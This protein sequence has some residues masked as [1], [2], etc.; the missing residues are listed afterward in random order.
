MK[1]G[2]SPGLCTLVTQQL[3]V[4]I[5]LVSV[6]DDIQAWKYGSGLSKHMRNYNLFNHC[7]YYH[8]ALKNRRSVS[9]RVTQLIVQA[10]HSPSTSV[11]S[12]DVQR[13]VPVPRGLIHT[14]YSRHEFCHFRFRRWR[15]YA[16]VAVDALIRSKSMPD[17]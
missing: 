5:Y 12:R 14:I 2:F 11:P 1:I 6:Q 16:D 10:C 15:P 4:C 13:G 17:D 3:E 8:T 9:S 7:H